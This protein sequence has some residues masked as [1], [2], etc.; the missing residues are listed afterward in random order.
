MIGCRP[1]LYDWVHSV[2]MDDSLLVVFYR[3]A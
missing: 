3:L 1:A 2:N